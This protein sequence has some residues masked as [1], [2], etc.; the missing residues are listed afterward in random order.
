MT[1]NN[2][3]LLKKK[4]CERQY[5]LKKVSTLSVSLLWKQRLQSWKMQLK[6]FCILTSALNLNNPSTL[7][8]SFSTES[9]GMPL[10]A[11]YS[12][13]TMAGG[14]DRGMYFLIFF[15]GLGGGVHAA[16]LFFPISPS[17]TFLNKEK[18]KDRVKKGKSAKIK[19]ES[20]VTYNCVLGEMPAPSWSSC[21]LIKSWESRW[22]ISTSPAK[23]MTL[24]LQEIE[25]F[26]D[27]NSRR[28]VF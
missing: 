25:Q 12:P 27:Q 26:R 10:A 7:S 9:S 20:G 2:T 8:R 4:I 17:T 22:R 16:F 13:K 6:I 28:F 14:F 5:P 18:K 19:I 24:Q 11:K 3:R 1:T 15:A 23:S 21:R